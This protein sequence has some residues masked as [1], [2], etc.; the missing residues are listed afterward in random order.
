MVS[1][2]KVEYAAPGPGQCVLHNIAG[3]LFVERADPQVAITAAM[4]A[5]IRAGKGHPDCYLDGDRLVI[6]GSN[7]QVAYLL[8]ASGQPGYLLGRLI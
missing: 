6:S 5:Q 1:P 3:R 2:E 8:E 4:I 7:Q